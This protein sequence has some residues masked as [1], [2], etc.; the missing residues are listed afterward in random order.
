MK[1]NLEPPDF[2]TEFDK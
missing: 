2:E 1:G